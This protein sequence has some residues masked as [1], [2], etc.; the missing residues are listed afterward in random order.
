MNDCEPHPDFDGFNIK[1]IAV[2]DFEDS[3][4]INP[5]QYVPHTNFNMHP[6][7][8]KLFLGKNDGHI[9]AGVFER[10]LLSKYKY[11]IV[12]R[13]DIERIIKEQQ[14]AGTGYI[15][16]NGI[17]KIG[18]LAGADAILTGRVVDAYTLFEVNSVGIN[19]SKGFISAYIP[20]VNIEMR[21]VH[22]ETGQVLWFCSMKRNGMNYLD[23]PVS[24]G[25]QDLI[26][27]IHVFNRILHGAT[28]SERIMYVIEQCA[29]E[30][31]EKIL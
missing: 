30:A 31:V 5:G 3:T 15:E 23:K 12:D 18:K 24:V 9:V 14:F 6:F 25:N 2:M 17:A 13:R 1:K 16:Q 19:G 29:K 4:Q 22:V 21:L 10:V 27:D 26:Q 11:Q 28:A 8:K 7:D 20:Y